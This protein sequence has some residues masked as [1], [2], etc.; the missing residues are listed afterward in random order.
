[1]ERDLITAAATGGCR[2]RDITLY[3]LLARSFQLIPLGSLVWR[4]NLLSAAAAVLAALMVYYP[5]ARLPILR[6]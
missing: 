5:A 1:M 4:T 3:V 2:T 6:G